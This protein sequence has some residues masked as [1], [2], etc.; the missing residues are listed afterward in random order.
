[1]DELRR[2]IGTATDVVARARLRTE[3]AGLLRAGNDLPSAL[4]ELRRAADE[5][6]G[7]G[8]VRMAVLSAA[9]A[10]PA[11]D[12]AAFLVEIGHI[13]RAEIAAWAA[14]AAEAQSE[15]GRPVQS[16]RAWLSV[17]GDNRFPAHQRRAAARHAIKIAAGVLPAEHL[18]ALQLRAADSSGRARLAFL[19]EAL[20]LASAEGVD[21]PA[22]L[23]AAAAWIEAGGAPARVEPL[24]EAAEKAGGP[25]AEEVTRLRREIDRR[26]RAAVERTEGGPPNGGRAHA[27]KSL[28]PPA[29]VARATSGTTSGAAP[30]AATPATPA[31]T[32]APASKKTETK[33]ETKGE[34]GKS[35]SAKAEAGKV[36]AGKAD[37][38]RIE[39][40]KA[41]PGKGEPGK[42][43]AGA[44]ASG[45]SATT[46]AARAGERPDPWDRA[47][48]AARAGRGGLARRLAEQALRSSAPAAGTP[49]L[50]A[51]EAALRQGGLVKQALLLRRTLLEDEPADARPAA[52]ESLIAEAEAS[53]HA[54]LAATWRKDLA[55]VPSPPPAPTDER[56][57]KTP[58][59]FYL[60]AQRL[61]IRLP[62]DGDLAPVLAL[63]SHAVAGHAGAD[64][65]LA[66][67]E[68]LLRRQAAAEASSGEPETPVKP[69]EARMID[70][71]RAASD[72]E[73]RPSRHARI[74]DR[75]AAALEVD[76][77][78]PAALAVLERA[79]TAGVL[80][81]LLP[82]R[83][84]RSRLL[85]QLG[86]SRELATALA[87][88][89]AALTGRDRLAVLAERA[90]LF[91]SSGEPERAL[92]ERLTAL[93][94]LGA[95]AATPPIGP[96]GRPMPILAP[97]RRRLESTGRFEQSL[98]LAAAAVHHVADRGDRLKLLR[99]VAALSEK[100]ARD[101]SEVA[102]A[103]L[104]VLELDPDDVAAAE[105]AE[106]VLTATGEW[107]RCADLLSWAAARA[108]SGAGAGT[109]GR[110]AL[111]WRLAELRRS[112]LNQEDEALRL[113]RALGAPPTPRAAGAL[114]ALG[115]LQG[116]LAL[117]TARIAVAPGPVEKAKALRRSGSGHPDRGGTHRRGRGRLLGGARSRSAQRR[118]HGGVRAAV[119]AHA[120]LGRA[121]SPP[122]AEGGHARA[123][124]GVATLVRRGARR[125]TAR[126]SGDG[127]R[128]L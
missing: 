104:A 98:R 30:G 107:Q 15:A 115:K 69:I 23:A 106:R 112:R 95:A 51:V 20:V 14:A 19:R 127:A 97:A 128:R 49:R 123:R 108:E 63:L 21:R 33:T 34:T 84:R 54:A 102:M 28:R 13:A 78:P 58:A 48:A 110:A 85:R 53:G 89:A 81:V 119:R 46:Q 7:L 43:G 90:Q 101:P 35:A 67:G 74:A 75:L 8:V 62:A 94:E 3:L 5:A 31:A 121:R 91:D 41:E 82:L 4:A 37:A 93:G 29:R 22:R 26:W 86:R 125:R 1:M 50:A 113:Y 114:G 111:L 126:R 72:S 9:R 17:A 117:H 120:A 76:G 59:E 73:D 47:L 56:P 12:R 16:A 68:S 87:S 44:A 39:P 122:G 38:A 42:K 55:E 27:S 92:A 40:G 61:L 11:L 99:D 100:S 71:L 105:A 57:P 45:P 88:D 18:A 52:L 116:P 77:D 124:G 36:E 24:L 103:W 70:L 80:E 2:E 25:V 79:I 65:A 83:R 10:L 60:A 109:A 32:T 64:T 66:L 6:P 96:D 118:R